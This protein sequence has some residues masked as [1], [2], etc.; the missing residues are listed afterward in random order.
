MNSIIQNMLVTITVA[1][2]VVF[3][4]R[5]FFWKPKKKDSKSCGNQNCGCG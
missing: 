5:K 4:V 1:F 3:L 2:A